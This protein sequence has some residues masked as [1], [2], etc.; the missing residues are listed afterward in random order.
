VDELVGLE[1]D[2]SPAILEW[3]NEDPVAVKVI[4]HKDV[5]VALAGRGWK[6]ASEIH[7]CLSGR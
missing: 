3:C 7:V 2:F 4:Y 6:L 5:T 1:N